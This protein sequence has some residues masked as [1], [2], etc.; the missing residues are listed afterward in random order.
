MPLTTALFA[1]LLAMIWPSL[2]LAQA[3]EAPSG[4]SAAGSDD[5]VANAPGPATRALAGEIVLLER[6]IAELR[7]LG[8]WQAGM[9]RLAKSDPEGAL[10][11]RR[12]MSDCLATTLA[13]ACDRLDTLFAPA[14]DASA[15]AAA[16]QEDTR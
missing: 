9:L 4:A 12:P 7:R 3:P 6:E 11:Q 5:P 2:S 10:G 15:G 8:A 16:T 1:V 13:P 14:A